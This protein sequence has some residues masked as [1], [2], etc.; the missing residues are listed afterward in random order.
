VAA[1]RG[2][3][4]AKTQK[5]GST[6]TKAKKNESGIPIPRFSS[7]ALQRSIQIS[8]SNRGNAEELKR[9]ILKKSTWYISLKNKIL[10]RDRFRVS[11]L[12]RFRDPHF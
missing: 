6:E 12:Q 9:G 11:A 3:L 1:W 8:Q 2:Q 4:I 7:S 5:S 10:L